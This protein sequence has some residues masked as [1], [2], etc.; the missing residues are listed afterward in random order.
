MAPIQPASTVKILSESPNLNSIPSTYVNSTINPSDSPA[1]DPDLDSYSIPTIDFSLLTSTDPQQR[2]EAI[3]N[4]GKACQDWGF[5]MVVNHGIPESLIKEVIDGTQGFFNLAE[6]EKKEIE[7]KH[8]LDPIRCGTSFNTSKEKAFFWID[9]LKVFLHPQ[10]HF[11]TKPKG[12]SDI[13]SEYCEKT[14][15]VAKKL[16]SGISQGLGLEECFLDKA[17]DMKSG[18]QVFIANLYPRCPQPE[19]ALG[20]PPH[21]HH[22]LLTLIIQNQVGGLQVQHQGKWIPVN[23]LPNSLLVNS[24]DHLEQWKVQEQYT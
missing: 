2:S 17:L 6:E 22:G 8:V 20:M 7:G 24:G 13:A 10:F 23:A 16:L 9:Y 4:L 18:F 12:Y 21:S 1:S 11:P 19:L 14:R 5:F 3:D 15:E